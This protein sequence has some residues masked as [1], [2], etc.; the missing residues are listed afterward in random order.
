MKGSSR[1][2]N[3]F[4]RNT[5]FLNAS[6][7][8]L[9]RTGRLAFEGNALDK[10]RVAATIEPLLFYLRYIYIMLIEILKNTNSL[11]KE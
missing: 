5:M 11:M 10:A 3:I 4:G 1:A 9:Y 6:I 7:Q 8:G 2:L